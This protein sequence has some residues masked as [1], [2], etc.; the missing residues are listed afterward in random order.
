MT[1][2][3][4][5]ADIASYFHRTDLTAVIPNFITTAESFLFRELRVK[6]LQIMVTGTTTDGYVT[7]PTDFGSV[8]KLT[9]TYG[10]VE[11]S[12]D[13]VAQAES[14]VSNFG[15]PSNY[16]LDNNKLR[17]WSAGTNQAYT[18][19][20]VPKISNLGST[21]AT[22]WILDNAY[23][24]YLYASC[25]EGAKYIRDD[26]ELQKLTSLLAPIIESVKRFSERRGQPAMGSMQIKVRR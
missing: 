3:T 10:G 6:E 26:A 13:Y 7:L 22:N 23:D 24:L 5:Q 19:Y 17:I 18:L 14:S 25:A 12:L 4:L 21:V 2:T 11:R 16:S 15:N 1:Y 20:Y 9:T 8:A